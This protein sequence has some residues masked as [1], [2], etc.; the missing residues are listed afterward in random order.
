MV[1]QSIPVSSL[2]RA[3]LIGEQLTF[4]RVFALSDALVDYGFSGDAALRHACGLLDVDLPA[5]RAALD[6]ID[7]GAAQRRGQ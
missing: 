4:E 5:A 6:S 7:F 3:P 2:A 1:A